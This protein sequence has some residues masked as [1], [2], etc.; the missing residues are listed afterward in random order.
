MIPKDTFSYLMATAAILDIKS[1]PN[2]K[3]CN[4]WIVVMCLC[5]I[6]E[7]SRGRYRWEKT[8][9]TF[10]LV[11]YGTQHCMRNGTQHC[12]RNG[13]QHSMGN[14]KATIESNTQNF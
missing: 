3:Q 8:N 13:T 7:L 2:G 10:Y 12:M 4:L 11:T 9:I 6:S 14:A 5:E 1:H